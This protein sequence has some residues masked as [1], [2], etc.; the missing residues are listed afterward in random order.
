MLQKRI[1]NCAS[2]ENTRVSLGRVGVEGR[3]VERLKSVGAAFGAR[4]RR[5]TISA[6]GAQLLVAHF[7]AHTVLVRVEKVPGRHSNIQS[8][9]DQFWI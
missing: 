6:F 7:G 3:L 5:S 2:I 4:G 9:N 8:I 1:Q